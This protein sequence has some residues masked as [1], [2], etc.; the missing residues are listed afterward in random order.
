MAVPRI[1]VIGASSGGIEALRKLVPGLPRDFP[2]PICVV[3]HTAPEAVGVLDVLLRRAGAL[4]ASNAAAGERLQAGRIYVAPP[5][6]HLLVEPGALHLSRGPKENRFRP[7]IDPLFRSAAQVYGPGA[8]GVI[9]SGSLDDGTA[10]LRTIK[11]LGGIAV[12]QDPSD[13]LYPSMPQSALNHIEVDHVVP[14]S[15]IAPLL[16]QLVSRSLDE[17]PRRVPLEVEVEV[18]IA[19]EQSALDAGIGEIG[20]PSPF[21][22]PEC[23]GVLLRL[24]DASPL[25]FR[26]HTGH[27]YTADSLIAALNERIED[28]LWTAVR[29]LQ[30]GML[31]LVHLREHLAQGNT[32]VMAA[33]DEQVASA[34]AEIETVRRVAI[35]R[36]GL[37]TSTE[38]AGR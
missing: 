24:K 26:C 17:M 30:E 11:Q 10:G 6:H 9:L 16:T 15:D 25:R 35:E 28:V 2:A 23:H 34:K 1:V 5:D 3:V 22:C 13:A 19:K 12:V 21:T 4:P 32:G 33:L 20:V 31:L 14:V 29:T 8:V 38:L 36:S 7:A 18:K 37:M 27:G